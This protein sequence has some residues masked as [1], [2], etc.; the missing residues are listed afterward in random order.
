M[1]AILGPRPPDMFA[2]PPSTHFGKAVPKTRIHAAASSNKRIRELF[3]AQVSEILWLHKLSPETTHLPA[4]HG[5]TEIQVFSLHLKSE[6][7]DPVI[8]HTLDKAIPFPLLCEIR[9]GDSI[10]FAASYKRPSDADAAK[11]VIEA[12]F[13]LD[14]QPA[15]TPRLPPPVA[16]DLSSL[17]DQLIRH[18]IAIPARTNESLRD[19]VAR[20][21]AI[22]TKQREAKQLESRLVRE[23]QF[24]RKVELNQQLRVL[25]AELADLGLRQPAAPERFAAG[26]ESQSGSSLPQSKSVQVGSCHSTHIPVSIAA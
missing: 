9:H 3:T 7:F 19:H 26:C 6:Q 14:W 4:R 24:N 13:L 15:T 12:N 20:V 8:L 17:H 11:W 25:S 21:E 18:H 16:L 1:V 23:R 5:I 10:R 2:Y 22:A